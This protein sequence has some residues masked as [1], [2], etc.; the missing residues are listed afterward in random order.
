VV[1]GE[2]EYEGFKPALLR[3]FAR[4]FLAVS[5]PDVRAPVFFRPLAFAILTFHGAAF[6]ASVD[7]VL[8]CHDSWFITN[9]ASHREPHHPA[10]FF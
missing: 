5:G 6:L 10:D 8:G 9:A 7:F 4:S 1:A 2:R 3:G